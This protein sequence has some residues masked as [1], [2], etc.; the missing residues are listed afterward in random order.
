[1]WKMLKRFSSV[2]TRF[3]V[4]KTPKMAD[5]YSK[6]TAVFAATYDCFVDNVSVVID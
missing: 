4:N 2:P 1:M 6:I 5:A 3:K